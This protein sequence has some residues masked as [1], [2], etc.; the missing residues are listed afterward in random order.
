MCATR[1]RLVAV[2]RNSQYAHD[3]QNQSWH[4]HGFSVPLACFV[5]LVSYANAQAQSGDPVEEPSSSEEEAL[6]EPPSTQ[7]FNGLPAHGSYLQLTVGSG[8]SVPDSSASRTS[9]RASYV[10]GLLGASIAIVVSRFDSELVSAWG[11]PVA[12]LQVSYLLPQHA[13]SGTVVARAGAV[14]PLGNDNNKSA[15]AGAASVVQDPKDTIYVLPSTLAAR[16]S[17]SWFHASK[18]T[19]TQIDLGIDLGLFGYPDKVHPVILANGALG[20]GTKGYFAG[21]EGS[22][23]LGWTGGVNDVVLVGAALHGSVGDTTIG[24]FAGKQDN[25][26]VLRGRVSYDY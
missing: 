16:G 4:R 5:F 21:I 14:F 9:L 6:P 2:I 24:F 22:T 13:G 8:S 1:S 19:I 18:Y 12:D 25:G 3:L 10:D 26:I 20:L 15:L 23:A 17:L 11:K 7:F